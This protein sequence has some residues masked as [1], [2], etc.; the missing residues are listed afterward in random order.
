MI[1]DVQT[2]AS[3]REVTTFTRLFQV[4]SQPTRL[5][6]VRLLATSGRS[7]CACE[8]MDSI[9]EPEYHISRHL[10]LLRDGGVLNEEPAGQWKYFAVN[11]NDPTVKALAHLVTT[12][13]ADV[14][15][16]DDRNFQERLDLRKNGRCV[17]GS[18]KPHLL[19]HRQQRSAKKRKTMESQPD[20]TIIG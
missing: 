20:S 14:F 19:E 3:Q 2:T 16:L 4:L 18:L 10:G 17:V 5:R 12:L 8:L 15:E 11:D 6:I 9:E 1:S 13:Y 7:A